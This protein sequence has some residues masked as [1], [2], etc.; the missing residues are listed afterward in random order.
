[1]CDNFHVDERENGGKSRWWYNENRGGVEM[2]WLRENDR[3]V[4]E[5]HMI[6]GGRWLVDRRLRLR[7]IFDFNL[8]NRGFLYIVDLHWIRGFFRLL[9]DRRQSEWVVVH[10]R[11]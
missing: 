6:V 3:G 5:V 7:L 10:P 9:R 4:F 11:C 1:M 2:D 8:G